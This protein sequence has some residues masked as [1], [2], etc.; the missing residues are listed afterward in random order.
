MLSIIG[1]IVALICVA[2]FLFWLVRPEPVEILF[3]DPETLFL[4]VQISF[5]S[6]FVGWVT[7][8][9]AVKM[10][11]YPVHFIGWNV[12]LEPLASNIV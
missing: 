6:G 8:V 4:Y 9:V 7:N 5:V 11:F 10:L 3:A 1:A 2:T 12:L